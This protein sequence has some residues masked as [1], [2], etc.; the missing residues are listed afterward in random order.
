MIDFQYHN[1]GSLEE[2]FGL[3]QTHGDN[4]R[5]M[6]GGTALV[7]M[8]KQ[9][10][11]QPEHVVSLRRI[12]GLA[13][14][15]ESRQAPGGVEIG[16]LC[17]QRAIE[18]S[19]LM[20]ERL[21]L[22]SY[23]YSCIATPRIRHMATVGGGLVHGDPSQD[24]PPSLIAL[25]A[26]VV[27]TS[28]GGQR[29]LLLEEFYLDYYET[30]VRPGEVLTSLVIPPAPPGSG[31]AYLKFLP[32]TADDYATVSAAA[33]VTKGEDNLCKDLR[34]VLGSVGVTPVRAVESENM[35]RGQPLS[36]ENIRA[37]AAA[38]KDVIDPLEDYRGSAEYK[39]EMAEV[40]ARR[41]IEKALE[42]I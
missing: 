32:R 5:V 40:F 15:Q 34:L 39:R 20:R 19:P 23:A 3:L 37:A 2:A 24:P 8:M 13:N 38:V 21:P 1:V 9:R 14:I 10:L 31:A 35:L 29:E 4:A 41:A 16:P 27:M 7:I 33:V 17:T 18:V 42:G 12:P 6:A 11:M 22:V 25:G 26:S 36:N 28:S 30:D